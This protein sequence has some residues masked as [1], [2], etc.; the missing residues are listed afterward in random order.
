MTRKVW[1]NLSWPIN[2]HL[3]HL[4]PAP[5]VWGRSDPQCYKPFSLQTDPCWPCLLRLAATPLWPFWLVLFP[6][7]TSLLIPGVSWGLEDVHTHPPQGMHCPDLRT[8]VVPV[9]W[10]CHASWDVKESFVSLSVH[11]IARG[12]TIQMWRYII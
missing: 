8:G 11:P 12:E 4:S 10:A 3:A 5:G 2:K 1:K 7:A 9:S 6:L